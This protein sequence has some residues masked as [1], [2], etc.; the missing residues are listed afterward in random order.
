MPRR[1]KATESTLGEEFQNYF[2]LECKLRRQEADVTGPVIRMTKRSAYPK[3][4]MQ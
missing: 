3:V 1:N 4:P 2:L